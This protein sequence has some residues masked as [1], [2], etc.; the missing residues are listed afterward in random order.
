MEAFG[1]KT[2]SGGMFLLSTLAVFAWEL[3]KSYFFLLKIDALTSYM[4]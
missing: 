1:L 2:T 4:S 3:I